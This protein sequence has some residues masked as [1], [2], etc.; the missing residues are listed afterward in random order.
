MN[1]KNNLEQLKLL[2]ENRFKI[3]E[4]DHSTYGFQYLA[5][6]IPFNCYAEINEIDMSFIFRAIST[7]VIPE[8]KKNDF[9]IYSTMI[10]YDIP[11]GFFSLNIETGD[12][13]WK[14]GV[15]FRNT[16][17]TPEMMKDVL[18]SSFYYLKYYV[19]SYVSLLNNQPLDIA[20]SRVGEDPG[21][22][23]SDSCKPEKDHYFGDL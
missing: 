18:E 14:S 7:Q 1:H 13:R 19:L 20:L 3:H 2:L 21:I 6:S 15:F 16:V 10:N 17:L 4:I 8:D 9:I 12:Y 5:G 23:A 22:G 11:I